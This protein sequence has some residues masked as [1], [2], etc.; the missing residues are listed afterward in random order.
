MG[1]RHETV[2]EKV[3]FVT[4]TDFSLEINESSKNL[5]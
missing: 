2:V 1:N 3:P 4:G 5:W